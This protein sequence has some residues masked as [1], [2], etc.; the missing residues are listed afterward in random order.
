MSARRRIVSIPQWANTTGLADDGRSIAA[1][2]GL[3]A[4]GQ[5]PKVVRDGRRDGIRIRDHEA[6]AKATP[7]AAYL[8]ALTAS[9]RD[10]RKA[11]A[12]RIVG[13]AT[14]TTLL[15][16]RYCASRWRF[17]MTFEHWLKRR[18]RLKDRHT[19]RS[20]RANKNRHTPRSRRANKGGGE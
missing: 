19:P 13:D 7:W 2:R 20:R 9:D 14:Y 12:L 6:W 11:Q 5:G 10:E 17:Q 3:I 18:Q 8:A 1:A 15:Y 16:D 4:T